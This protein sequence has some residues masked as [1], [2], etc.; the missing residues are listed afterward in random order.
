MYVR[1]A[2]FVLVAALCALALAPA[3]ASAAPQAASSGRNQWT[4]GVGLEDGNGTTGLA[5]R[6]DLEFVQRRLAPSV[7]FSIVGSL[8]YSYFGRN[9]GGWDYYYGYN[10][11]WDWS[12]NLLKVTG[13]GRLNFGSSSFVHPY[14]EAGV[15]VYY[16]GLSGSHVVWDPYYGT[17]VPQDYS[18]S[19]VSLLLRV[20]G[21]VS[22]QVSP[23][24]ALGVDAGVQAYAGDIAENT[25][26]LLGSA[27][28]RM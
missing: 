3:R 25:F 4:V 15:G 24:F 23:T 7:G 2:S 21:G 19:E 1:R 14:A 10:D 13:A 28:F 8:G 22:F 26:A 27:T 12:M 11:H 16:A 18:D 9:G 20:G 6:G 5:L 17:Y